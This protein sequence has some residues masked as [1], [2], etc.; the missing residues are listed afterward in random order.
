MSH[1]IGERYRLARTIHGWRAGIQVEIIE[2]NEDG[3]LYVCVD[4]AADDGEWGGISFD[5]RPED[6]Q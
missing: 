2:L 4:D 3:T 6:L 5:V 1:K